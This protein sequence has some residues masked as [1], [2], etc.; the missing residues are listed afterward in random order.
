MIARL[1]L[2][3]RPKTNLNTDH[4]YWKLY[5]CWMR[6]GDETKLVLSAPNG[7][8]CW[9]TWDRTRTTHSSHVLSL[10]PFMSSSPCSLSC[11]A[12]LN[13]IVSSMAG[14][15]GYMTVYVASSASTSMVYCSRHMY[16]K[17]MMTTFVANMHYT[18]TYSLCSLVPIL[19]CIQSEW[20]G[21]EANI[22]HIW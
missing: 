19:E 8:S 5:T 13:C 15:Q 14:I 11:Q 22:H 16:T 4:L 7:S 3:P 6:S 12:Y 10:S 2:S 21:N 18:C 17:C 20:P 1:S 9:I